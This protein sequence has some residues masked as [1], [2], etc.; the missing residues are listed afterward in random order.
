M[1]SC[2]TDGQQLANGKSSCQSMRDDGDA[3][4]SR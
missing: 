1:C 4:N 2:V 3:T